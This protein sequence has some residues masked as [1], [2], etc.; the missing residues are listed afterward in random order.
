MVSTVYN[1]S[2][3]KNILNK[4]TDRNILNSVQKWTLQLSSSV[5]F[6]ASTKT[7]PVRR[8]HYAD[9]LVQNGIRS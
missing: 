9:S 5:G 1:H 7:A 4:Q 3:D 6:P 2:L 8:R